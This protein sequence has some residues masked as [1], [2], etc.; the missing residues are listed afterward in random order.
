MRKEH[1]A[2]A[3]DV[4]CKYDHAQCFQDADKRTLEDINTTDELFKKVYELIRAEV[5]QSWCW[6]FDD[7]SG[8]WYR[9]VV[10]H[11]RGNKIL[12][13]PLYGGEPQELETFANDDKAD[14]YRGAALSYKKKVNGENTKK[15]RK[16]LKI[17]RSS[18][19]DIYGTSMYSIES[20]GDWVGRVTIPSKDKVPG[21]VIHIQPKFPQPSISDM[22]AA[23]FQRARSE[24]TTREG[25]E[26]NQASDIP[27]FLLGEQFVEILKR[28][29]SKGIGRLYVRRRKQSQDLRGRL[30]FSRLSRHQQIRGFPVFIRTRTTDITINRMLNHAL[31]HLLRR[32]KLV[33]HDDM[34]KA[35]VHDLEMLKA[36][37]FQ[38]VRSIEDFDEAFEDA[39]RRQIR[40]LSELH[41][42]DYDDA[43][44]VAEHI[45]H[46]THSSL[47]SQYG[48]IYQRP[49]VVN[50]S[51]LFE[52]FIRQLVEKVLKTSPELS[53]F[54]CVVKRDSKQ[55]T[56]W[57]LY[58][59]FQ[60]E[61]CSNKVLFIG[62]CKW[63][64]KLKIEDYYQA[65]TYITEFG[66]KAGALIY[67]CQPTSMTMNQ[68]DDVIDV[69]VISFSARAEETFEKH[70]EHFTEELVKVIQPLLNDSDIQ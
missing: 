23:R 61:S 64:D 14:V 39:A 8:H 3:R 66:A 70:S 18:H 52:D 2:K 15:E 7:E 41:H 5:Q 69:K 28:I 47:R 51:I 58:N 36:M 21:I 40:L 30:D 62:E 67:P 56:R 10:L 48:D 11:E 42:S 4:W 37:L 9:Y 6:C 32:M 35:I 1:E 31:E 26:T 63:K 34:C 50:M 59:D 46:H 17:E 25:I 33:T 55:T 20:C 38:N 43:I 13:I 29:K 60:I 22:I 16:P 12:E 24:K 57:K 65:H 44:K 68:Q 53:K 45:L 27:I 49:W 54:K 19:D